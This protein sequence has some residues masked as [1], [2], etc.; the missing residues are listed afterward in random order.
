[1]PTQEA[2]H[3][4]EQLL[5]RD[6]L[7]IGMRSLGM[8][9]AIATLSY[10]LSPEKY[11]PCQW[12]FQSHIYPRPTP[13]RSKDSI[14][15]YVYVLLREWHAL[16]LFRHQLAGYDVDTLASISVL[17]GMH[18]TGSSCLHQ[19]AQHGHL[20]MVERLLEAGAN[21]KLTD[22]RSGLSRQFVKT[23]HLACRTSVY[24]GIHG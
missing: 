17:G 15:S 22:F 9:A 1:M 14:I 16:Q 11:C 23:L 13:T 5:V 4:A 6:A 12:H 10:R 20:A 7:P 24:P 18:N 8:H 3:A 19:A 21:A 2:I